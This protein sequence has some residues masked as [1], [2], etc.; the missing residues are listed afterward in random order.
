[1]KLNSF[2]AFAALFLMLQAC[3]TEGENSLV[4][5][6]YIRLEASQMPDTVY[7]DSLTNTAQIDVNLHCYAENAC[8]S[9]LKFLR[10]QLDDSSYAYAASGL[11]NN[12]DGACATVLVERDTVFTEVFV[13]DSAM[14]AVDTVAPYFSTNLCFSVYS[15][16]YLQRTD[17]VVV[18][19]YKAIPVADTSNLNNLH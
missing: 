19:S 4:A 17:K 7:I 2:I 1:M 6:S 11:F 13:A 8:W 3:N 18:A 12:Q 16:G 15:L 10:Q 14:L 9:N 5:T